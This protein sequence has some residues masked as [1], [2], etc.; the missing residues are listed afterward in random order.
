[1]VKSIIS[2]V[3]YKRYEA[4][5]AYVHGCNEHGTFPSRILIQ[6]NVDDVFQKSFR[7]VVSFGRQHAAKE[8]G[9]WLHWSTDKA[10]YAVS[11]TLAE[12][13][14]GGIGGW[15]GFRMPS[16]TPQLRN[17]LTSVEIAAITADGRTRDGMKARMLVLK[18]R[19]TLQELELIDEM[20]DAEPAPLKVVV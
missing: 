18:L 12:P 17:L 14:S 1:M 20:F 9:W 3:D 8:M 13:D 11:N 19:S 15:V 2:R 4:I 7:R 16:V 10:G 5:V 6:R